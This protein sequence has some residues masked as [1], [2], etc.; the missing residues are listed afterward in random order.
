MTSHVLRRLT[1]TLTIVVSCMAL[2]ACGSAASGTETVGRP[3]SS[4]AAARSERSHFFLIMLEN[5]ELGEVI[6]KH[7]APYIEALAKQGTLATSYDAITH[8]SLPNYIALLAGSPLGIA[9]DCTEC[10]AHGSNLVDQLEAAHISWGAYMQ[11]LPH[12]CYAGAEAGSYAK[13]HDPFMYFASIRSNPARCRRVVPYAQLR[14][15]LRLGSLPAFGWITPNLCNDGHNCANAAPNSFLKQLVPTLLAHL[16]KEGVLAITWD[17]GT[18]NHSCCS[19]AAGGTVP[20]ILLGPKVRRGYD[21]STA[22][23][24]Y[25]L[26]MLI[27]KSFGLPALRGAACGCTPSLDAAFAGSRPPHL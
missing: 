12:P 16:G 2:A 18:T 24:S 5:R 14:L 17:E 7:T 19:K 8:P 6:G 21:L 20:L 27:E 22:A 11:G 3:L 10:E 25:S 23:D 13:K 15:E 4:H 9:S 26:L 1:A